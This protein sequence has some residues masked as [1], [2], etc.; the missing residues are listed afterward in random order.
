MSVQCV[1]VYAHVVHTCVYQM[2]KDAV[3]FLCV[4]NETE[5][6]NFLS[7]IFYWW[8]KMRHTKMKWRLSTDLCVKN[9]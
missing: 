9:S 1:Y 6:V 4:H 5:I 3:L 7:F 2:L 8:Q